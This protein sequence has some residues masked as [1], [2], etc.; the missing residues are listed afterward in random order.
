MGII[1]WEDGCCFAVCVVE[2]WQAAAL[3]SELWMGR[4]PEQPDNLEI[5]GHLAMKQPHDTP[6]IPKG[7][8]MSA[9]SGHARLPSTPSPEARFTSLPLQE[10]REPTCP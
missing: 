4:K 2:V 1:I 6:G 7:H 9:R 5:R 3:E 10:K 8:I